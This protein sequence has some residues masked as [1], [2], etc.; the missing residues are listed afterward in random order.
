MRLLG[1]SR[2]RLE[3]LRDVIQGEGKRRR[4][5]SESWLCI[6]SLAGEHIDA[7]DE[8]RVRFADDVQGPRCQDLKRKSSET[9]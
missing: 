9:Q 5:W 2:V 3:E 6:I 4:D 7:T 8:S 1:S